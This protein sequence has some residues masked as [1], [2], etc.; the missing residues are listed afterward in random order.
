MPHNIQS[1]DNPVHEQPDIDE[2]IDILFNELT[3]VTGS[4]TMSDQEKA[5]SVLDFVETI[6]KAIITKENLRKECEN[7]RTNFV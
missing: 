3:H 5:N 7:A 1:I 2:L 6:M 4:Q